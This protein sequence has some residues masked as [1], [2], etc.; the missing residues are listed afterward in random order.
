MYYALD[1]EYC[2]LLE[3]VKN[4]DIPEAGVDQETPE[5][6]ETP[7]D[8]ETPETATTEGGPT[9]R[10]EELALA[11]AENIHTHKKHNKNAL[12]HMVY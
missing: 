6:P 1:N 10:P 3:F 2:T 5:T 4:I 8:P 7:E 9:E 11:L 12:R